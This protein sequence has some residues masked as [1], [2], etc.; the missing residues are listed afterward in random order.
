MRAA[1]TIALAVVVL[2]ALAV[3]AFAGNGAPSGAHYN[4]NILGKNNC[5]GDDLKGTSRHSIFVL[6]NYSDATPT[7]WTTAT[8]LDKRNKIFLAPG[9][10]QVADG[11]ACD[12]DGAQFYLPANSFVC[13][14]YDPTCS[15]PNSYPE[16]EK[17]LVYAR[18]LGTPGGHAT[19]TTC[20][21]A[22][23]DD[24]LE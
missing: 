5:P 18:A 10:F 16:F 21:T 13:P 14:T 15:G 2:M 3:P 24:V 19:I 11:N 6:L 12:G 4:L 17:Y 1:H 23:V 22:M 8:A 9:D 7:S 20:A